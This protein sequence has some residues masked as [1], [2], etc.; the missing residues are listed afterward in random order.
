MLNDKR[1]REFNIL[2]IQELW[3]NPGIPTLVNPSNS[4]FYLV[5]QPRIEATVYFYINKRIDANYWEAEFLYG[6]L[7]S[8]Q[9]R[10]RREEN[11]PTKGDREV[12]VHNIYNPSPA[13]YTSEGGQSTLPALAAMLERE[14]EHIVIGDFNLH[15]PDWNSGNRFTQHAASAELI[16]LANE[17]GLL[18]ITQ[19]GV[20]TRETI[21]LELTLDLIFL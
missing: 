19:P 18:Q 7:A 11:N 20:A 2:A 5:N 14:R 10:I 9:L 17:H 1:Y 8:L 6:D 21:N 4:L 12:W 3:E 16:R 13:S 15:H